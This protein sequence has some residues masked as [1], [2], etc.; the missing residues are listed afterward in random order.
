MLCSL[1][2]INDIDNVLVFGLTNRFDS[3]DPALTRPGRLE[4][5]IEIGLPNEEARLDILRIH[6]AAMMKSERLDSEIDL[7]ALAQYSDGFSGA[8]LAGFIRNAQA[9]ALENFDEEENVLVTQ[10]HMEQ[11]LLNVDKQS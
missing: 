3:L 10:A 5:H 7:Q 6:T 4:V 11:A 8:E 2:G 1:D 9:L